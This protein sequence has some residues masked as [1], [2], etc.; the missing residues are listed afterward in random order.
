MSEHG[1]SQPVER[2]QLHLET[3]ILVTLAAVPL[4]IAPGVSFYFDIT[5]KV[6]VLL[7]GAGVGVLL[8]RDYAPGLGAA[9]RD[10]RGRWFL[11]LIVAQAM[12]LLASTA[13]STQMPLSFAGTNWRRLGLVPH[14]GLLVFAVLVLGWLVAHRSRYVVVFRVVTAAGAIAA[15]YGILQYFG[16]DPLIPPDA[17]QEAIGGGSIVRP[18]GTVGHAGYF[19][20]YLLYVVFVAGAQALVDPSGPWRRLGRLTMMLCSVA[21][22]LSGTRSA[23]FGLVAGAILLLFWYRPRVT[24]RAVSTAVIFVILSAAFVISPAGE[25]LRSRAV[26][27]GED[28]GGGAR[29]WLWRDSLGMALDYWPLG[30]GPETFANAYPRYQSVELARAYPNF[31]HESP[32]NVFLD[33]AT[34]QGLPGLI[35]MILLVVAPLAAAWRARSTASVTGFVTASFVAGLVS[36]QFLVFTVP[37]ALYFYFGE[38]LLVAGSVQTEPAAISTSRGFL[39]RAGSIAASLLLVTFAAQ[40]ALADLGLQQTRESVDK[41]DTLG[42]IKSHFWVSRVRP[43][44]MET[45]TW[46]AEAVS[47]LSRTSPDIPSRIVAMQLVLSAS[48]RA[49]E[50]SEQRANAYCRLATAHANYGNHKAAEKALRDAVSLAPRWYKPHLMLARLLTDRGFADQALREA[51]SAVWLN[52]GHDAE[53]QASL[54]ALRPPG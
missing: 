44:G 30:S 2:S 18:P 46:F 23:L 34:A 39:F 9:W 32:H 20:T 28:L 1:A 53:V 54:E 13:F 11:T 29:L 16:I 7:M 31:Y 10:R 36:Q 14:L 22:V 25:M 27:A 24:R 3:I 5:P 40:L 37:T 45:D 8:W 47:A 38:A 15:L 33:A 49:A 41:W 4:L 51:E 42:A 26:W 52:G 48:Q 12:S 6:V 43:W 19:A 21:I 35:I 50:N 17:Y